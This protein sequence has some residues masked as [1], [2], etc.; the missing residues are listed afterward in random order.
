MSIWPSLGK[1]HTGEGTSSPFCPSP[2]IGERLLA[3]RFVAP[4]SCLGGSVPLAKR[5][6]AI[7]PIACAAQEGLKLDNE[8]LPWPVLPEALGLPRFSACG[9]APKDCVF[10]VG[11]TP[12][13]I[14][15]RV[16]GCVFPSQVRDRLVPLLT[17]GAGR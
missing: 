16:F 8:L 17:E 1:L 15:S 12:D 10:V 5:V 9:R 6:A 13:S 2:A 3:R 7:G 14:D 4:G 11:D